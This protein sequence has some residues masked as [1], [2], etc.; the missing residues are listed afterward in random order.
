MELNFAPN[1]D[2]LEWSDFY[3]LC[4]RFCLDG[5]VDVMNAIAVKYLGVSDCMSLAPHS[6][7]HGNTNK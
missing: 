2:K 6:N 5:F 7:I 3:A 4:K 1:Q